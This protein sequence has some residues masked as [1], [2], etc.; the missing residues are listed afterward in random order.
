M[1]T[2]QP[3]ICHIIYRLAVGGLEN[4]LVNLINNLPDSDYRQAIVCVTESTDFAKRIRR[5]AVEIREVHKRS[6]K[7][8][9]AYAR[10]WHVLRE[11]RPTIVHTRNLPA[12]DM[13]LPARLAGVRR[14]V[15][16]EHGLDMIELGGR[17]TKYNRLRW[18]SQALVDRYLTVS[19]DLNNWLCR[20]VGIPAAKTETIYNGVDTATFSPDGPARRALPS[21]FAP[22]GTVV[23]GTIGRLDT[24]KNQLGLARAVGLMLKMRPDVR[25]SL[26]LVIVGDGK[27]RTDIEAALADADARD[28]AWL[29]GFRNDTP[30]IYRSL[31]I[32]VLPS[33][34]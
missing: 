30:E 4:G 24:L 5:P 17:N 9:P 19:H 10:M 15:H 29:P 21:G 7:D 6:G 27:Q 12:L 28:L 23:V 22:H 3:L 25:G 34:R 2:P 14:F 1:A 26:R 11:L 31:D 8:I 20:E 32:F 18:A 33:F 13:L 16:S